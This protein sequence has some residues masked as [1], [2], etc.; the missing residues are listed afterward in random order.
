MRV[1]LAS[2]N[3]QGLSMLLRSAFL[4]FTSKSSESHWC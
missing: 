1:E 2:M 4:V 3:F